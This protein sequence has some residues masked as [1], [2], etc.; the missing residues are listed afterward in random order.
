MAPHTSET[1]RSRRSSRDWAAQGWRTAATAEELRVQRTILPVPP[2]AASPAPQPQQYQNEGYGAYQHQQQTYGY[3]A[4]TPGAYVNLAYYPQAC[5]GGRCLP[6][7]PLMAPKRKTNN[8]QFKRN[9]DLL[10]SSLAE[11]LKEL[12]AQK[13]EVEHLEWVAVEAMLREGKG[14]EALAATYSEEANVLLETEM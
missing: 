8:H 1:F 9:E 3:L 11:T 7:D 13:A 12:A 6:E 4:Q 5:C 10:K 14:Y 2:A